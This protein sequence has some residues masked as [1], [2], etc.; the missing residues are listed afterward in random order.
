MLC[1]HGRVPGAVGAQLGEEVGPDVVLGGVVHATGVLTLVLLVPVLQVPVGGKGENAMGSIT[2]IKTNRAKMRNRSIIKI[3]VVPV[4][5]VVVLPVVELRGA[6]PR[7]VEEVHV[8]AEHG[9]GAV[10]QR[11]VRVARD[12][13][14][15][16]QLLLDLLD[17]R[18]LAAG[19]G[20]LVPGA[21]AVARQAQKQLGVEVGIAAKVLERK[22]RGK[23]KS[24]RFIFLGL[25]L[26]EPT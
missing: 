23:M 5:P 12:P 3:F 20:L 26:L 17:P 10:P 7:V 4:V 11:L 2:K 18:V 19:L 1:Q 13:V 16:H 6:V 14:G 24:R 8:V 21:V 25:F 22:W 15:G 9:G